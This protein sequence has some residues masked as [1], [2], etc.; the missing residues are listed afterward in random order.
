MF[1][2]ASLSE[3][4]INGM[5]IRQLYYYYHRHILWYVRHL[6]YSICNIDDHS[7]INCMLPTCS[8]HRACATHDCSVA[9][10]SSARQQQQRGAEETA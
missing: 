3:P 4:H 2:G 6:H 1:I 9:R 8:E 7:H 10:V 5:A